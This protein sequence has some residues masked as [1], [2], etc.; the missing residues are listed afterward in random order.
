MEKR[1]ILISIVIPLYNAERYIADCLNSIVKQAT[2]KIEVVVVDDGSTD[3]SPAIADKFAHEYAFVKVI[4][5]KNGGVIAARKNGIRHSRGAYI[6]SMDSDDW[7][8]DTHLADICREIERCYPDVV[9]TGYTDYCDGV[10][11]IFFQNIPEGVYGKEKIKTWVIPQ[12]LSVGPFFT[13][14]I[15]PTYWTSCIRR[16]LLLAAVE[17]V[18]ETF[19]LGEDIAVTYPCFLAAESIS[20]TN[21][22]GYYYRMVQTSI[23]KSY[24][25][26][27]AMENRR[28]FAYL[29]KVLPDDVDFQ[30]QYCEYVTHMTCNL[31]YKYVMYAQGKTEFLKAIDCIQEYL[32]DDTVRRALSQIHV[33]SGNVPVKWKVVITLIRLRWFRLYRCLM[34]RK[35]RR[36]L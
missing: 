7:L 9:L 23:T 4:H 18:P 29:D 11:N 14:G 2:Q 8:G 24:N 26:K 25:E 19:S 34:Q 15:Y 31:V 6:F 21:L 1:D 20:V 33:F 17:Q 3:E 36:K 13:Y 28:L 32:L 5:Q 30:R 35:K 16:E 22:T 12:I 27:L 10:E